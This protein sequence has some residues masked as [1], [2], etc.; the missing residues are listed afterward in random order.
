M[1]ILVPLEAG[2]SQAR[3][4]QPCSPLAL[5]GEFSLVLWPPELG[6]HT[7]MVV[8]PQLGEV[9]ADWVLSPL[10]SHTAQW[11]EC[12]PGRRNIWKAP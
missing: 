10:A 12:S 1:G 2:E 8:S 3:G 11:T 4:S 9:N 7:S 6:K 5:P